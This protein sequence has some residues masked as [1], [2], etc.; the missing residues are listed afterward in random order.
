MDYNAANAAFSIL[1]DV[2]TISAAMLVRDPSV[3]DVKSDHLKTPRGSF[4]MLN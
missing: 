1:G 3:M 4:N 2:P